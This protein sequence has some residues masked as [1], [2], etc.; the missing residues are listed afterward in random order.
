MGAKRWRPAAFFFGIYA[1]LIGVQWLPQRGL[2]LALVAVLLSLSVAGLLLLALALRRIAGLSV[3]DSLT[4]LHNFRFFNWYLQQEV[5][6]AQQDRRRLCLLV[7]DLDDFKRY[8][9]LHGHHAGNELLR[10]V[11][12]ILADST[13][14]RSDRVARFG[15][16]E[17]VVLLI[18]VSQS[19]AEEVARRIRTAT[20]GLPGGARLSIGVCEYQGESAEEFFRK[21]DRAMYEAKGRGA[22]A[23]FP[24]GSTRESC[25]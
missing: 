21:A 18:G 24:E 7:A 5:A 11:A 1:A 22:G 15:G 17:F 10:R 2:R 4:G 9:D 20:T 16:D 13:R 8:N 14:S 12:R 19:T 6:M 25:F 23:Q 3:R